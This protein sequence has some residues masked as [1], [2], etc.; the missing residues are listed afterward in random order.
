MRNTF[1]SGARIGI[2]GL[3]AAIAALGIVS[4]VNGAPARPAE[5][6]GTSCA[7]TSGPCLTWTNTPSGFAIAANNSGAGGASTTHNR[8]GRVTS[9]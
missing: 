1:G 7:A 8:F 9:A 4:A 3:A 5:H 2:L 6:G